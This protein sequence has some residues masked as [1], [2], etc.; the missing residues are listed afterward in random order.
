MASTE[1]VRCEECG[2]RFRPHPR[3]SPTESGGLAV[4]LVC[5]M[6]ATEY[7]SATIT[8]RGVELRRKIIEARERGE[9]TANPEFAELLESFKAEVK[10]GPD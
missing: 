7:P 3:E 9:T 8:A 6:C 1:K 2:H 4:Y 5:P 10:R